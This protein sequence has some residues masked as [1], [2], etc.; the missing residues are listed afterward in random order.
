[1]LE[2]KAHGAAP[3]EDPWESSTWEGNARWRARVPGSRGERAAFSYAWLTELPIRL[4][5]PCSVTKP[6]S[7]SCVMRL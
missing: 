4:F 2:R 3:A 7:A 6:S 1:M 5:A